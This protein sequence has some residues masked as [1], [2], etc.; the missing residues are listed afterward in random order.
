MIHF[1]DCTVHLIDLP[2]LLLRGCTDLRDDIRDALDRAHDVSEGPAGLIDELR[3]VGHP[4]NRFINEPLDL[5]RRRR[6]TLGQV[7]HLSGDHRKP[8]A[9]F[10]RPRCFHRRVQGQQ[11]RLEGDLIDHSDDVGNL[12]AASIDLFHRL[13]GFLS[14]G[15][16]L[17]SRFSRGNR[18]MIGLFGIIGILLHGGRHM[19]HQGRR[20]L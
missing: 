3:A 18:K 15:P 9:M 11:I 8:T 16:S 1:P 13:H 2:R 10:A 14:D 4:A 20:R 7:T 6:R 5:F 12:L 19:P 17:V